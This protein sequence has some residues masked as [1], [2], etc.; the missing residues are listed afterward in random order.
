MRGRIINFS[1]LVL[2]VAHAH[3]AELKSSDLSEIVVADELRSA[4]YE[5]VPSAMAAAIG[6]AVKSWCSSE[7][8][9]QF[10]DKAEANAKTVEWLC[11]KQKLSYFR[12]VYPSGEKGPHRIVCKENLKYMG[13][14]MVMESIEY[15]SCVPVQ[16]ESDWKTY[17]LNF[18]NV[19]TGAEP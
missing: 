2:V 3:A 16:L 8:R 11:G 12:D 7:A 15:G 9:S 18:E 5:K 1:V 6:R 10:A 13:D 17:K 4:F 14:D 19:N